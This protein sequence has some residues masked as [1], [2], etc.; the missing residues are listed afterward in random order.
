[1][2]TEGEAIIAPGLRTEVVLI[3]A[4]MLLH[5]CQEAGA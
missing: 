1:M 2:Q 4:G 3:L 5:R